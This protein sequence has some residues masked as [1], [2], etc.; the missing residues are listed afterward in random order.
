MPIRRRCQRV[1]RFI[2]PGQSIN[3]CQICDSW[4]KAE[5]EGVLITCRRSGLRKGVNVSNRDFGASKCVALKVQSGLGSRLFDYLCRHSQSHLVDSVRND[6]FR[7]FFKWR[8]EVELPDLNRCASK[9]LDYLQKWREG[10]CL[11]VFSIFEKW[12]VRKNS[13]HRLFSD[14]EVLIIEFLVWLKE[15]WPVA[16]T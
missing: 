3:L 10:S 7:S 12:R 16:W 1:S 8:R 6:N 11:G 2:P 5:K 9:S 14:V 15:F 4:S 13:Y